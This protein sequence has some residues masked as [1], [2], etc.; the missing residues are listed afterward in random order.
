MNK[1]TVDLGDG[2]GRGGISANLE[3]EMV[4]TSICSDAHGDRRSRSKNGG[5]RGEFNRNWMSELIVEFG[6]PPVATAQVQW[7][8]D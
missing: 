2:S 8:I 4:S 1:G 5:D 7:L 6:A 3:L